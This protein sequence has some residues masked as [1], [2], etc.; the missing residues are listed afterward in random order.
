MSRIGNKFSLMK[1]LL[2][3]KR[4]AIRVIRPP[5]CQL[6][7]SDFLAIHQRSDC[8]FSINNCPLNLMPTGGVSGKNFLS[9]SELCRTHSP[10]IF[11]KLIKQIR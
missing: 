3:F 9:P 2:P 10:M 11:E 1:I 4:K 6:S 7:E 8:F 5:D